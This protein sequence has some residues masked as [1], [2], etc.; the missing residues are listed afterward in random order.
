MEMPVWMY[1]SPEM[2]G[3]SAYDCSKAIA[4]GLRFRP[5]AETA[6]DTLE[7]Y[8]SL[9]EDQQR[10]RTGVDPEKEARILQAWHAR[11]G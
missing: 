10:M 3:F 1:P 5:L 2:R 9:P 6:L 11:N 8:K 4:A 7:W